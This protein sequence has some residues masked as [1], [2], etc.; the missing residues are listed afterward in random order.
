MLNAGQF[1]L[2][3]SFFIVAN[4]Q[5]GEGFVI[6]SCGC[7]FCRTSVRREILNQIAAPRARLPGSKVS[8]EK[9]SSKVFQP[10]PISRLSP[11]TGCRGAPQPPAQL[12]AV[13]A[14]GAGLGT[15]PVA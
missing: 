7:S 2:E 15:V 4:R 1:P 14:R 9:M 5:I 13:P 12:L 3:K 11:G 8:G 6:Y 10:D